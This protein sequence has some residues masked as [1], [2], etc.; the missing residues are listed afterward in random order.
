[1]SIDGL[2]PTRSGRPLLRCR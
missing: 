2:R 1:M